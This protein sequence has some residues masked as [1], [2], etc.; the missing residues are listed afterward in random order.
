MN[1]SY[2]ALIIDDEQEAI[3][4]LSTSLKE[5]CPDRE[6]AGSATGSEQ[7]I[8]EFKRLLPDVL[9][10]DIQIDEKNGLEV[11]EEIYGGGRHPYV[12]FVTAFDKHAIEAF[13][14]NAVDY[15]LKPVDPEDLKRACSKFYLLKE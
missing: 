15:L 2:R 11:V 4:F 8:S 10:V 14:K 12:I 13:R 6:V 1:M 3:D 5:N 9:F 7:A